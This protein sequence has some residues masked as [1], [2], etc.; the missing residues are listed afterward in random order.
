MLPQFLKQHSALW[1][2]LVS[3]VLSAVL[4]IRA[5]M[6]STNTD[7]LLFWLGAYVCGIVASFAVWRKQQNE[8]ADLRVK[9][10][11]RNRRDQELVNSWIDTGNDLIRQILEAPSVRG[12]DSILP[13]QETKNL[14]DHW[15]AQLRQKV[16]GAFPWFAAH[17][18][19][20]AGLSPGPT[21]N[22]HPQY[23]DLVE[24]VRRRLTRLGELLKQVGQT[25]DDQFQ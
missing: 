11:G 24:K 2:A 25:V 19:S 17:L 20:D 16:A 13:S 12:G 1:L 14:V 8:I 5:A 9:L 23:Q 6:L 15:E 7:A 21:L 10:S 18:V 22:M 3:T 4:A